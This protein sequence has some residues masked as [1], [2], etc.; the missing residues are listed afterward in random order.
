MEPIQMLLEEHQV[1]RK[2]LENLS[3]A[4]DMIE[5]DEDVPLGFFEKW[6]EFYRSFILN[7]HHFKE[8]HVMF[9]ELAQKR[10]GSL[11]AQI[12]ALRYQHERGRNF[13]NEVNRSIRGYEKRD[14]LDTTALLEN[15]AAYVSLLRYHIHREEYIFYPMVSKTFS[16]AELKGLA[17]AFQTEDEKTQF[18]TSEEYRGLVEEMGQIL[19]KQSL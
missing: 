10:E 7:F 1:I 3:L 14:P 2:A 11:D 17:E 15:L 4:M 12:E 16:E 13:M 18:K 9:R 8:E 6:R 19:V 5:N